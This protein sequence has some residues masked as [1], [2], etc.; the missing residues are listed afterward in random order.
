MAEN[1]V[2]IG[3]D[4]R[5]RFDR[6]G[7][8]LVITKDAD[9]DVVS[10]EDNL[11]QAIIIRL[12][13]EKGELYDIGHADYGSRL[14]EMIGEVN[15]A[16]T[17]QRIKAIVKECLDQEPRIKEVTNINLSPDPTDPHRVNIEITIVPIQSNHYLTIMYPFRLEG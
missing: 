6:I 9:L 13:T 4:L 14:H 2:K 8:D 1:K 16:A 12:A 7:A 3:S 15:N 11:T 17:R 10:E 5:L